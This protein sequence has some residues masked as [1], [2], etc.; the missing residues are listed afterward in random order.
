MRA[1]DSLVLSTLGGTMDSFALALL[2]API[3]VAALVGFAFRAQARHATVSED[4]YQVY[5]VEYIEQQLAA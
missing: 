2:A 4:S 3:A 1:L 5:G